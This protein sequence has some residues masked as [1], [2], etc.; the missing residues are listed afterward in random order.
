MRRPDWAHSSAWRCA[1]GSRSARLIS[2][3]A[4]GR[5]LAE[6]CV[7]QVLDVEVA[8]ESLAL[9]DINDVDPGARIHVAIGRHDRECARLLE[10][11]QRLRAGPRGTADDLQDLPEVA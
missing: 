6:A 4:R 2:A 5:L 10:Q 9:P 1:G 3:Q 11:H 7:Y 8:D